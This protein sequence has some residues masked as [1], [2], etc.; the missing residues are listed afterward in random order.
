MGFTRWRVELVLTFVGATWAVLA[1]LYWQGLYWARGVLGRGEFWGGVM[2]A[3]DSGEVSRYTS[4]FDFGSE[5]KNRLGRRVAPARSI[6]NG[7][8]GWQCSGG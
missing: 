4:R 1:G 5:L 2:L 7:I 8:Y 6:G 3:L